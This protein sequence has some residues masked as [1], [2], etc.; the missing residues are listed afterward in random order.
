MG[1]STIAW[2]LVGLAALVAS[3]SSGCG[4]EQRES[5][6]SEAPTDSQASNQPAE[7]A[8]PSGR[9][10]TVGRKIIY[11]ARIDLVVESL[12]STAQTILK[13]INEHNGFL[14]ESDESSVTA[15]Q[16]RGMWRVRVPIDH[17]TAFVSAISR[18]GEVRQNHIGSQDV[19]E[20]YF[21]LE[22]RFRN[23]REEEKR[24]IKHLAESTGKL[25]DILE[26]EKE[27]S[28]VRGEV[29]QM[30]GR[31]RLLA[32]RTELSTVTIEATEWKDYKPPIA[33]S[34]PTQIG[35]TFFGSFEALVEFGKF[36]FLVAVALAPW[37]PLIVL[38]L[39]VLRFL[40]RFGRRRSRGKSLFTIDPQ[41][42]AP[43]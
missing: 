15:F 27:L 22:A 21:D 13:L 34:F 26:V 17:F 35:R 1:P 3:S 39:F 16:R 14:A 40:V 30:E 32:N 41:P 38:G 25:K 6:V 28:R 7:K 29:E 12:S 11:D 5:R 33:A 36:F 18:L 42:G 20:E 31:L 23:K 10:A 9:A 2:F 37:F 19:T 24:L 8:S 4:S 43:S